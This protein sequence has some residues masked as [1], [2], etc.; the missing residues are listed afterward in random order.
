M[1]IYTTNNKIWKLDNKWVN[2]PE[3]VPPGP[4]FDEVTIGTQTWLSK[5]LAIDDG[6]E[7]I[8]INN[9]EYYYTQAAAQRVAATVTGWHLPSA[10]EF[11]TLVTAAVRYSALASVGFGNGTNASGFDAKP[12]GGYSGS[13][14]VSNVARFWSSTWPYFLNIY[15]EGGN[16]GG[17]ITYT[18]DTDKLSVRLVKDS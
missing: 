10:D 14:L 18:S 7:G 6:G 2:K 5:N 13:T 12:V 4:T 16:I 17:S 9:G 11:N 1:A 15:T 8:T 3:V